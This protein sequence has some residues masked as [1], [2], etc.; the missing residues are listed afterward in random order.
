MVGFGRVANVNAND[1]YHLD[2]INDANF[3]VQV[4]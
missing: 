4:L 1:K 2:W 3:L